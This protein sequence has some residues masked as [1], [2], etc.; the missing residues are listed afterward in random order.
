MS[1][2][3]LVEQWLEER[4]CR[5]LNER[6]DVKVGKETVEVDRLEREGSRSDVSFDLRL[7]RGS[8]T[9]KR[10]HQVNMIEIADL[11]QREK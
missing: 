2:A 4:D 1:R 6:A 8:K 3:K 5:R 10:R 11:Q 9:R 7:P